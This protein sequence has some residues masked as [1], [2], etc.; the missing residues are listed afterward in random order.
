MPPRIIRCVG[1]QTYLGEIQKASLRK[2][3]SFLCESCERKRYNN[4]K[5]KTPSSNYDVGNIFGD[6]FK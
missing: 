5:E 6:I 4:F 3:I 1:C 2:N